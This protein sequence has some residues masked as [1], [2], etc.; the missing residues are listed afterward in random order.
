MTGVAF[1]IS[2]RKIPPTR[3]FLGN[4]A[5]SIVP[6]LLQLVEATT[7]VMPK[8]IDHMNTL[9]GLKKSSIGGIKIRLV[10]CLKA[11]QDLIKSFIG[12]NED[13]P[14]TIA[15]DKLVHRFSAMNLTLA[16]A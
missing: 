1:F 13:G 6:L 10:K 7:G 11:T 3:Q 15:Q 14:L 4:S 5:N 2:N 9:L 8:A 16:G 12:I